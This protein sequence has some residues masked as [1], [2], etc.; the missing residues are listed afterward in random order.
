M[1]ITFIKK[2]ALAGQ[3]LP[4]ALLAAACAGKADAPVYEFT[5]ITRGTIE[6]TVS[7]TGTINPVATVKVLPRMSGKV[8]KINVDYND[9]I[10]RGQVLAELNTDVLRLQREQQMASVVKARA[11]YEL[12]RLNYE[13]QVEL[14]AK[15][16]ISD[17]ELKNAR[18]TFNIQK[19]EL[20]AA[21][22][23]L[24]SIETEIN[25]YAF[26]T[27]P[28][29]GI[30]LERNINEGDTVVDS[31]SSNSSSIFTLAENLKEMQIE[32]WVGE[33]DI[34][35]IAEGQDV[36]FTL[37]SL[38]GRTFSGV[39]Q[40]KRLMPSVQDNVVSYDVIISVDN[41]DGSLLPGMTCTVEFIQERSENVLLVP[42]AALRYK[43]TTLTD[44]AIAEKVFEA[45]LAGLSAEEQAKARERR[46]AQSSAPNTSAADGAAPARGGSGLSGMLSGGGMGGGM[47]RMGPPGGRGAPGQ[48]N[49]AAGRNSRRGAA[50][51]AAP[52]KPLW[53]LDEGG[54][55]QA[56]LVRAGVSDGVHTEVTPLTR[57]ARGSRPRPEKAAA[58]A[59]AAAAALPPVAAPPAAAG[60]DA[61]AAALP[62][63]AAQGA[64]A[65]AALPPAASPPA[66]G[67]D[68]LPPVAAPPAAG[69]DALPP[70]AAQGAGIREGM[71]VILRE[72]VQ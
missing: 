30:V 18:T 25:Q 35:A 17:Y 13:Y 41:T 22:A 16:L 71:Q 72:K 33:L 68:A 57:G 3:I 48:D 61:A 11:N 19:A 58:G 24:K 37:E 38:P 29:D 5:A 40:S 4:L 67:A 66:A 26:I 10:Q 28:I 65:A 39:V 70:V 56:V 47:G 12:Q 55:L 59:D 53:Y 21:E 31:S 63:V 32:S 51:Q 27:S 46:A 43:P 2:R 23:N 62:P 15:N 50:S 9:T 45:G 44:E 54:T 8:E 1:T 20:S 36:R 69:A 60:A 49:A 14:A 6:K 7:S 52:P 42:N 64:D 34:A